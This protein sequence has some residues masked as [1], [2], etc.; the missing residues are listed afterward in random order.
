[1]R[2]ATQLPNKTFVH[3]RWM[4][5]RDLKAAVMPIE[6]ASFAD[7]YTEEEILEMLRQRTTIG[8]VAEVRGNVVG[9]MIYT[10]KGKRIVVDNFAVAPDHRRMG[11]GR[12]MADKLKQKL[13]YVNRHQIKLLVRE[14]NLDAQL[15]WRA[16]GFRCDAILDNMYEGLDESALRFVYN[17]P[18]TSKT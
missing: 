11:I 17:L 3:I 14:T 10:F 4:I 13:P 16:V 6:N 9:Y 15:F 7:P 8:M 18:E 5:R 1:M 2:T 12:A